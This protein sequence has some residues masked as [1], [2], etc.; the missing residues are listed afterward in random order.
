LAYSKGGEKK[1]RKKKA[2]KLNLKYIIHKQNIILDKNISNSTKY[3]GPRGTFL[4][5]NRC[6]F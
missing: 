6:T 2:W 4:G 5:L 3:N 1:K